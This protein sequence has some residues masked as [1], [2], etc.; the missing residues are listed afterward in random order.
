MERDT[1]EFARGWKAAWE[2]HDVAA[3]VELCAPDVVWDEPALDETLHG[4]EQVRT[5]LV[6]TFEAFP[7]VRCEVGP[8]CPAPDGHTIFVPYRFAGTM[9]GAWKPLGIAPTGARVDFLAIDRIQVRDGVVV[10][11]ETYYDSLRVVRQIGALPRIGSRADRA[12]RRLQH[13]QARW[14]RLNRGVRP[15]SARSA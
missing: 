6:A 13:L 9:T 7:D 15:A 4:Q 12:M 8:V 10:R 3:L 11:Y 5:F 2:S 14:Q 1:A